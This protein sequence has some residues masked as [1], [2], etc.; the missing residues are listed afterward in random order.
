MTDFSRTSGSITYDSSTQGG[1]IP[2]YHNYVSDSG[3]RNHG[4][5]IHT[6]PYERTVTKRNG[7][8]C[9]T[10]EWRRRYKVNSV[11]YETTGKT[12]TWVNDP[13]LGW[14]GGP[15]GP[16]RKASAQSTAQFALNQKILAGF[17]SWDTLTDFA[18]LGETVS[19]MDKFR[20]RL[21]GLA[22]AF[23]TRKPSYALDAF[24]IRKSNRNLRKV[25]SLIRR[26]PD[27]ISFGGNFWMEYRY[28]VMPF[29]YS[30]Q[31]AIRALSLVDADSGSSLDALWRTHQVTVPYSYDTFNA[32]MTGTAVPGMSLDS[33]SYYRGGGSIRMK[34]Y[35]S[36]TGGLLS[37][38]SG[39]RL[40]DMLLT[41]WE[42]VPFS[43]VVDW[44]Y[45]VSGLIG[46]LRLDSIVT[47]S[48]VNVTEKTTAVMIHYLNNRKITNK[49]YTH[50]PLTGASGQQVA[51]YFRFVRS[52]GSLAVAVPQFTWGI[53][54]W[55]RQLDS[56][57]LSWQ[58]A[59]RTFT[60]GV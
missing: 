41:T 35:V 56:F 25:G 22:K 10:W 38:L 55:K 59:K 24:K 17:P 36:Y 30:I 16:S 3:V 29:I 40:S 28:G 39:L 8:N 54:K 7:R 32:T 51:E 15:T 57:V 44:F 18:E 23:W 42:L 20:H 58:H 6:T 21:W 49:Q 19:M 46:Q 1:A 37:K 9:L 27:L 5:F 43:F 45:N 52:R 26:S 2:W 47:D 48:F 50:R 12:S 34:A 4:D 11:T 60:Y 13:P 31:D 53:D 33:T 14:S